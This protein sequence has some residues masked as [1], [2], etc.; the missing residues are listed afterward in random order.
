MENGKLRNSK[1]IRQQIIELATKIAAISEHDFRDVEERLRMQLDEGLIK[2]DH[3]VYWN[4]ARQPPVVICDN[5]GWFM[6]KNRLVKSDLPICGTCLVEA[7]KI[8]LEKY[9][10][11]KRPLINECSQIRAASKVAKKVSIA[12][13]GID[14]QEKESYIENYIRYDLLNCIFMTGDFFYIYFSSVG[15]ILF[16]VQSTEPRGCILV[17]AQT[18]IKVCNATK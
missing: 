10:R 11:G 6:S 7:Q 3:I 5:C 18:I 12:A 9:F 17:N 4:K 14:L 1:S 8:I 13:V 16:Q 2:R 15:S